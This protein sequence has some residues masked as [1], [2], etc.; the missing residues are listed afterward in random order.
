MFSEIKYVYTIFL[1]KSFSK[2]AKK[3]YISQ[4]ALSNIVKKIEEEIGYQVFDRS[5][6]PLSATKEGEYFIKCIKKILDIEKNMKGYFHDLKN[7][8]LTPIIIGGSSYFCA[9]VFP[10]L[11]KKYNNMFPEVYFDIF[12]GNV[13]NLLKGLEEEKI[14]LIFETAISKDTSN[15][16]TYFFDYEYLILCVPI[17]MEIN[18]E[19]REYQISWENIK[20]NNFL[21]DEFLPVPLE[22]FK[23]V[24][25]IRMKPGNDLWKRETEICKNAGFVQKTM[26]QL[27]QILTALHIVIQTGSGVL[28][29]RDTLVKN[30]L[31]LGN[32]L[33]YYK[34]K[35][36]LARREIYIAT[37]KGKYVF[38]SIQKFINLFS[39]SPIK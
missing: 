12:E 21:K 29:V 24:P 22:K 1:E 5:T 30:F 4:P 2:A 36:D 39:K 26:Y 20:N 31:N 34:I 17:P 6:I 8:S 32:K 15:I 16:N 9:Y 10:K 7:P 37:K 13:N 27:D 19:L 28:F 14:D 11:I 35:D 3:L 38:N 18:D 25:F 23:D 33:V